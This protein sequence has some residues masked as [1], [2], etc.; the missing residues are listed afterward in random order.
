[1]R[2]ET[3]P[4]GIAAGAT[5][6]ALFTLCSLAVAIAPAGT[7]AFFSYLVHMDLSSLPRTLTVGGFAGG[8]IAWTLGTGLAFTF[9][10]A[11]YNRLVAPASKAPAA[12]GHQPAA[13][14]AQ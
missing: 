4:F 10:A 12:A 9:A 2:L 7:T 5:A 13:Q 1:M 3:R 11:I 8:L 14:G 6:A